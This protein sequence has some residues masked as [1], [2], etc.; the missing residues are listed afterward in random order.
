[1][2]FQRFPRRATRQ[3]VSAGCRIDDL[4]VEFAD[5]SEPLSFAPL[6]SI[7]RLAENILAAGDVI[8]EVEPVS[9]FLAGQNFVD[10]PPRSTRVDAIEVTS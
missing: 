4:R 10:G 2:P 3:I 8:A 9:G 5:G 6:G 7:Q 1:L